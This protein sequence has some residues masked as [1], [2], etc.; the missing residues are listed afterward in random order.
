MYMP[1]MPSWPPTIYTRSW[2]WN[3]NE[4]VFQ[5]CHPNNGIPLI[6]LKQKYRMNLSMNF[7]I[8]V[9]FFLE[10]IPLRVRTTQSSGNRGCHCWDTI[11]LV[12]HFHERDIYTSLYIVVANRKQSGPPLYVNTEHWW[13][14]K[15]DKDNER[16]SYINDAIE[17]D[18]LTQSINSDWKCFLSFASVIG[19]LSGPSGAG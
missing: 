14:F 4:I 3:T 12:S 11:S 5:Q 18:K 17:V 6:S 1:L 9:S 8:F 10:R 15:Y 13:S 19:C 7:C 16:T 2:N